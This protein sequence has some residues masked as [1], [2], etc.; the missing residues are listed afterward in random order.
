MALW[1]S[2]IAYSLWVGEVLGH[3]INTVWA[4]SC[5]S[6]ILL[7]TIPG[8]NGV[9]ITMAVTSRMPPPDGLHHE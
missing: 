4:E 1:R 3:H 6:P 5:I 8:T 9:L 2:G 7:F